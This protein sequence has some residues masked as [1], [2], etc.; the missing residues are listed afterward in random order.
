MV[1]ILGCEKLQ[2]ERVL[3]PGSITVR[4]AAAGRDEPPDVVCLQHDAHAGFLSMIDS[5]LTSARVHLERLNARRR[6]TCPAADLVVGMQ[7]GG[8]D[9]FSGVTA[10]PALGFAADLLVRAD[11]TV[12]FSE[13]TEVRDAIGQ[14]TARAANAEVGNALVGEMSWYDAC[15]ARGWYDLFDVNCGRIADGE[16]TIEELGWEIFRLLLDVASGRKTWAEQRKLHNALA[17]FHSGAC[18]MKH[19]LV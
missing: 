18:D 2:P 8:S 12:M 4:A 16:A 10:N 13:V 5:I 1:V 6:E 19:R 17:L 14:L 11:A 7:C 3:P 15:P 9:A